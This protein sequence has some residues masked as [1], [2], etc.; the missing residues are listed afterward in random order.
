[1][2]PI[3]APMSVSSTRSSAYSGDDAPS[4]STSMA[5]IATWFDVPGVILSAQATSMATTIATRMIHVLCPNASEMPVAITT[6]R[7]TPI[8][9]SIALPS[10]WFDARLHDEQR[11]DRGEHRQ[12]ARD[13][14]AGDQPGG[15]R[16]DRRLRDLQDRN[17]LGGTQRGRDAH[18]LRLAAARR[19]RRNRRRVR[20]RP[21]R[22]REWDGATRHAFMVERGAHEC[23][24]PSPPSSP[25]ASTIAARL[26][27]IVAVADRPAVERLELRLDGVQLEPRE[28]TDAAGTRIHVVDV[29]RGAVT[30]EYSATVEGR[31]DAASVTER[32]AARVPAPE[33]LLRGRPARA[34]RARRVLGPRRRRT[35]SP[36]SA[37]GSARASA[38]CRARASRPTA[39]CRRCSPG[40][41][42]AATTRT[43]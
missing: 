42:C 26:A 23:S 37:R 5:L 28:V 30:L 1:M 17:S 35:C 36:R 21:P 7:I 2:M 38:T 19:A 27:F 10:D 32:G 3:A 13:Q 33:P 15:D 18:A 24:D 14:P 29:G 12:R 41:A 40:R 6:P 25:C 4:A 31:A 16:R 20:I 11:R 43:S 8:E 22:R 39:P 9:R 34:D